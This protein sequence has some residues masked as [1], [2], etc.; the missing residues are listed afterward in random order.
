MESRGEKERRRR[1][2]EDKEREIYEGATPMIYGMMHTLTREGLQIG[3]DSFWSCVIL[4]FQ[5]SIWQSY[6]K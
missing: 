2:R 1:K 4:T 3:L 5:E 6:V